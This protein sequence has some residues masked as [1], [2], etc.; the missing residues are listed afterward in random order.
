MRNLGLIFGYGFLLWIVGAFQQ[1]LAP[2]F[3]LG[4]YQPDFILAFI[5]PSCL[6]LSPVAATLLGFFAGMLHGALAGA[7]IA[8]YVISRTLVCFFLPFAQKL[9]IEMPPTLAGL[10]CACAVLTAKLLMI[11]LAPPTGIMPHLVHAVGDSL[12]TGVLSAFVYLFMQK[13]LRR[14]P[15]W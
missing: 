15:A 1:T 7:N 8:H 11:F 6:L 9:E 5:A 13:V 12:Y 3:A 10:L 2:K 14:R 4:E